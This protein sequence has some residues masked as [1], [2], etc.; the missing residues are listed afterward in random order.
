MFYLS[1]WE[2]V[3]VLYEPKSESNILGQIEIKCLKTVKEVKQYYEN[4]A[5]KIKTML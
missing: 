1:Q 4:D 5:S 3:S 2:V